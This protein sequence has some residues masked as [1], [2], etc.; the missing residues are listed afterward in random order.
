MLKQALAPLVDAVFPQRCPLCGAVLAGHDGLCGACWG[1]LSFPGHPAC[2]FCA[3]PFPQAGQRLCEACEAQPPRHGG[4]TA[5][6]CYDA[7]S[8]QLVLRFKHGRQIALAPML[9]RMIATRLPRPRPGDEVIVP[10]PL[11][12]WRL[13]R[14]GYNQSALLA[15]ELALLTGGRLMVDALVRHKRTPA[16]GGLSRE[17]RAQALRG[18][19][20]AHP[21]RDMHGLSVL[22]VDDVLTSGAT[23]DAC[24]EALLVAGARRVEI[25][26]FARVMEMPSHGRA[27]Q[28]Q[29]QAHGEDKTKAPEVGPRALT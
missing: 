20:R 26:C 8:R 10:V 11:H 9:A 6:T 1:R 21:G 28:P 5:A 14:R 12:R 7:G 19:I 4:I 3:M 25:A 2:E 29:G 18:A 24:I 13:W 15:R 23:S 22:L 17:E 16:L 27:A